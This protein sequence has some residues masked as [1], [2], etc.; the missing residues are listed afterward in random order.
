MIFVI[1]PYLLP[2]GGGQC[3]GITLSI[4]MS[5]PKHVQA[6]NSPWIKRFSNNLAKIFALMRQCV[7]DQYCCTKGQGQT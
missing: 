3:T 1:P 2:R 6:L 4:S 7:Q 5:V